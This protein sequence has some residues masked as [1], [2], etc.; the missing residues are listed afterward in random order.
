M[1][2]KKGD[3]IERPRLTPEQSAAIPMLYARTGN[4]CEVARQ[5][6]ISEH[7]VR[8]HLE[9]LTG[10]EWDRIQKMQVEAIVRGS[11]EIVMACMTKISDPK[12]IKDM[13]IHQAI[14]AYKVVGAETRAWGL[15]LKPKDGMDSDELAA[16]LAEAEARRRQQAIEEALATGSLEPLKAFAKPEP[17]RELVTAGRVPA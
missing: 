15:G 12:A 1:M 2:A 14:G 17:E 7:A 9:N 16:I 4:K 5:L 13:S 11:V 10:E 8:H 3:T 6:G